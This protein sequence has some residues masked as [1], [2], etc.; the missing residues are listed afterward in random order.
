MSLPKKHKNN[1]AGEIK[2]S[3]KHK[4]NNAGKSKIFEVK[5]V[6]FHMEVDPNHIFG[7]YIVK[8]D[9][10]KFRTKFNY[11]STLVI[12]VSNKCGLDSESKQIE[13]RKKNI[14]TSKSEKYKKKFLE[15]VSKLGDDKKVLWNTY[16]SGSLI[17]GK[18]PEL[19]WN[20]PKWTKNYTAIKYTSSFTAGLITIE[21]ATIQ[22]KGRPWGYERNRVVAESLPIPLE[23]LNPVI[24]T[25][26]VVI[27]DI[28]T[29]EILT[30]PNI[31]FA[32][33]F[34]TPGGSI[35]Y[36]EDP[37]EDI[38]DQ[39]QL[40]IK[41]CFRELEEEAGL[42]ENHFSDITSITTVDWNFY[43]E[44]VLLMKIKILYV[45]IYNRLQ[46]L[47]QKI[48]SS[49]EN[50]LRYLP[51]NEPDQYSQQTTLHTWGRWEILIW[52]GVQ[53][54]HYGTSRRNSS[55]VAKLSLKTFMSPQVRLLPLRIIWSVVRTSLMEKSKEFLYKRQLRSLK[56]MAYGR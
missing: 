19:A 1:N 6:E 37:P 49:V 30:F 29:G 11:C 13:S 32:T 51:E 55:L 2:S 10:T 47:K 22:R 26:G 31:K 15:S 25:C 17:N 45:D 16:V 43:D 4:K 3:K 27:R 5:K 39:I 24:E 12:Y 40:A 7:S 52:A 54:V 41:N 38:E 50:D 42:T 23:G 8:T 46:Q 35:D 48:D 34:S 28:N 44:E 56:K 14:D 36:I 20:T 9:G 18:Y 53:L 33:D 21:E